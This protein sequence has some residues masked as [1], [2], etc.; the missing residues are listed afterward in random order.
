MLRLMNNKDWQ[1]ENIAPLL[2]DSYYIS[3]LS[4]KYRKNPL[5]GF[6]GEFTERFL[7][8]KH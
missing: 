4:E 1:V 7:I 3:M 2:L 8:L 5:F 6:L